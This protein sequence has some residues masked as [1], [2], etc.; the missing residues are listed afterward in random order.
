MKLELPFFR[1]GTAVSRS[2][3][4]LSVMAVFTAALLLCGCSSELAKKALY[5]VKGKVLVDGKPAVGAT[6]FFKATSQ[7]DG[8]TNTPV[9]E[10]MGDGTFE[11]CTYTAK[12]G[13][14]VGDY[15]VL[16]QWLGKSDED[17]RSLPDR[18]KKKYLSPG[19]SPLRATVK[20][21]PNQ[22]EPFSLPKP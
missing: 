5:P 16:I 15:I 6:V 1:Q 13:A 9:A 4:L 21:E 20:A 22:L 3:R 14:P 7:D 17:D 19:S 8:K 12:D 10:V 18:L 2:W 11:V